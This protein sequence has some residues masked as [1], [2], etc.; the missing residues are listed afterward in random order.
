LRDADDGQRWIASTKQLQLASLQ[1]CNECRNVPSFHVRVGAHTPR[2]LLEPLEDPLTGPVASTSMRVP[3]LRARTVTWDR[4]SS[5][6]LNRP[7]FLLSDAVSLEFG[8]RFNDSVQA[9]AWPRR[10]KRLTFGW[11]FNR[12]IE[13]IAWPTSLKELKLGEAFNQKIEG[14][15]WPAAQHDIWFGTHFNQE[16]ERFAWPSSLQKLIF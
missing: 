15:Q 12:P 10:L 6:D 16:V 14:I 9:V 8:Y 7:S 1:L 2:R 5:A 11:S 13:G 4:I 3:R